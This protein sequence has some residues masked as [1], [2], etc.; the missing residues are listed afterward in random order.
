[1]IWISEKFARIGK[2]FRKIPEIQVT[3][4]IITALE[5]SR[6]KKFSEDEMKCLTDTIKKE[7][8]LQ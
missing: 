3:P 8:T 6:Q 4:E 5:L 1:M 2:C 7:S